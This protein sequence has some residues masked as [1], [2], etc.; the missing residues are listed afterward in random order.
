M[1]NAFIR[2]G[3]NNIIAFGRNSGPIIFP[4]EA[5][6]GLGCGGA[7]WVILEIHIHNKG[8]EKNKDRSIASGIRIYST[9]SLREND[10]GT[11]VL[12]RVFPIW[13]NVSLQEN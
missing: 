8:L 6:V 1:S 10:I 13:R 11:L 12:V 2:T 7:R 5:G 4:P 9:E 3:K